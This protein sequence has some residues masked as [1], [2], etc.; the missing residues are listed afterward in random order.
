MTCRHG[1]HAQRRGRAWPAL[2]SLLATIGLLAFAQPASG[3]D[4]KLDRPLRLP[5][6]ASG[7]RCPISHGALASSLARGL[8]RMPVAGAGPVYLMSVGDDPAGSVGVG[9]ADSQGWRGQKAPWLA[10]P[11]YR[12]PIL[13]R[14]ARIDGRGELR[15]ARGT[16]EHLRK[17][18]ERRGQNVQPNG[19]RVWPGLLLARSPGCYALQIDGTAFSRV[20][21]IRVHTAS[22]W[23]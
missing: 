5:R 2:G 19:W 8:A 4:A 11:A 17:L 23:P 14:G 10:S 21:V 1:A 22:S 18:Y 3:H 20:I 7:A 12:G 15:F 9:Q 6:I 16:G 13:I